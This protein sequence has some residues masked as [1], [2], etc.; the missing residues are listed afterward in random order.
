MTTPH[1][2]AEQDMNIRGPKMPKIS[3]FGT[4]GQPCKIF[5]KSE[6][7]NTCFYSCKKHLKSFSGFYLKW[8]TCPKNLEI[9][10]LGSLVS[11]VY[12]GE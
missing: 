8:Q 12:N 2:K 9:L 6:N 3:N 7:Q 4:L 11:T 1:K 10:G 5:Y